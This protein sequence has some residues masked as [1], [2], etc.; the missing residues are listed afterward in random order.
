[1]P[2]LF[3]FLIRMLGLNKVLFKLRLLR[4]LFSFFFTSLWACAKDPV[5][6]KFWGKVLWYKKRVIAVRRLY[7]L[8]SE[9]RKK[10]WRNEK[11]WLFVLFLWD[12]QR[13]PC[14]SWLDQPDFRKVFLLEQE[15]ELQGNLNKSWYFR[16]RPT[17]HL[18]NLPFSHWFLWI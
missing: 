7:Q 4:W 12:A 14:L 11:S 2:S 6:R 8:L 3:Y 10:S 1:M 17:A 5:P 13:L 18:S 15:A 16:L 9:Q